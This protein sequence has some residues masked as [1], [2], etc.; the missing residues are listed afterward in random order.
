MTE[1]IRFLL[2]DRIEEVGACDPTLTV[3]DYLRE[4]KTMIGTKEGC[5][6]GDCGACTVVMAELHED[7]LRYRSVNSCIQLLASVDG[8]QLITVENLQPAS[9]ELHPVQQALVDFHGSQCG[10]CT[11]GF[12]MSLFGMYHQD[13]DKTPDRNAINE[14]LAGNLC[15]CTG[16][17]PIMRAAEHSLLAGRTDA[18]SENEAAT[19]RSLVSIN[20]DDMLAFEHKGRLYF[21]PA[22]ID[23]LCELLSR[24]PD[25]CM[26]AGATDV[27]LWVTKNLQ[28]LPVVI[29]LGNVRELQEMTMDGD[30]GMLEIGA[31]VTYTDAMQ[32]ICDLYPGF[33][34][35]MLRLG[36]LQVR[37]AGTIGGNIA[38]GSPIGDSPPGLIAANARLVLRS[39]SGSRD[40]ALEDFFIAYGKQD[41]RVGECVEKILLPLP[42]E[43]TKFST[44]KLSK[45]FDQDISAICG[46][47][48]LELD[49]DR[50]TALRIAYGGLA[51]TPKRASNC[52]NSLVGG[53]WDQAAVDRAKQALKQDFEPISDMRASAAYR[54]SAA[55]NLLQRFF[56]ESGEP[57]FP[58]RLS[59][60]AW[61]DHA[62]A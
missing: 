38:N 22:N 34:E 44:Y 32:T 17:A 61:S 55:Q 59:G 19:I 40:I 11:P 39:S 27:G 24:H 31:G 52:E 33:R 5:A 54:L 29:Y 15:R 53:A 62:Q 20:H 37:N 6:E 25:A 10:F 23:E 43:N 46:A 45:R 9:D 4:Q 3:L 2:N 51:A 30:S 12:V 7:G 36:G 21:S 28:V 41:L 35:V 13:R 56:L 57:E 16:Y 42:G 26:V 48:S 8:K 47:Y 60:Q 58:L 1:T 50:V 18:F 49:G 14:A